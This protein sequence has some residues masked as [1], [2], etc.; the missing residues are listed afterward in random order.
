[1]SLQ[2]CPNF[3]LN[4]SERDVNGEEKHFYQFKSFRL[5][6]EERQL[7][8]NN[9]P[10]LLTPKAF[11]VLALLVER[12]GHLIEKDEL[13]KSV[14]ADSFVEEQNITRIIHLLRK[15]LGED[16][17]GSKFIET[18]AKK[19][20]RFVAEVE[21]V[22]EPILRKTKN[23]GQ[24][25][26]T[27]AEDLPESITAQKISENELQ[28]PPFVKDEI[29][30]P[31]ISEP[32]RRMRVVLFSVGFL[33]AI[34]LLLLLSFNFQ[35]ESSSN[36]NNVKSF[37]ILPLKPLTT[38]NR[39][40]IYELG[41]ADSLIHRLGSTK[42]FFVR[43]LSAT[44]KYADIEQ[45]PLVA[46]REQKVDYVL[47]SNYQLAN[48]KI[49]VTAQLYNVA[50]GQIEESY[51]SEKEAGDVFTIQ[52]QIAGEVGNKLQARFAIVSNS[53]KA[54]RGTMNEEAYR[55]YLH[56]ENLTARRSAA[57]AKKAIESFGQAIRLDPNY[58]RAYSGMARAYIASGSL[59]GGL[60]REQNERAR[61]AVA[62][63]L[64]LDGNLAEAYT[65]RA[66]LKFKYEW[67][68]AG[69]E[70]DL[71]IAAE[72]D[73]N[74]FRWAEIR[75]GHLADRGRFDEAIAAIEAALEIDPNSLIL[76]RDRGRFLY[77]ARR[78][79]EAIV[80]LKRVLEVDENFGTAYSWLISACEKKGDYA[81]AYEFFLESVKRNNPENIEIYQKTHEVAGW[82]GVRRKQL[83]LSNLNEHKPA[84]NYYQIARQCAL[85]NEKDQAF[86]YLNK[87]FEKRHSQMVML[88]VEP[89]FDNLR[90]DPRFD[91]LLGRIGFK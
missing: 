22:H 77:F 76:Q 28:I 87:A 19:G 38:E 27:A 21:R 4:L 49:R 46:G 58:A 3:V 59:G 85:L 63:A 56:G 78:Y 26:S 55:L 7:L 30:A 34:F 91:E 17:N 89:A 20:Y 42:G 64:E 80:Q 53:P 67:D 32:K 72:L 18:V 82:Q 43:P 48:G 54:A 8:H 14:W 13:L 65:V 41:I 86:E 25:F 61:E 52:D 9:L 47:A 16:G 84:V 36:P 39:E 50:N 40:P 24:N 45:D 5:D 6:V 69:A 31:L 70:K 33:T 15:T 44:R 71:A 68:F 51:K 79:D 73:P 23:D 10:V 75:A 37:A 90:G 62:K 81:A 2:N 60:P 88:S 1:M 74:R 29:A 11:D 83:E 35:P 12:G 66:D 57:D